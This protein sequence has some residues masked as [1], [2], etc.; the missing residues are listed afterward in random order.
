MRVR[1][2]LPLLLMALAITAGA[3]ASAASAPPPLPEYMYGSISPSLG[4][5]VTVAAYLS[6]QEV[7]TIQSDATGS[8]FGQ[9]GLSGQMLQIQGSNSQ[10][11]NPVSFRVAG[12]PYSAS[13]A[14][15]Y[16]PGDILQ[17]ILSPVPQ[18]TTGGGSTAPTGGGGGGAVTPVPIVPPVPSWSDV[19]GTDWYYHCAVGLFGKGIIQG[20]PDGTFRPNAPVA[21]A[22]FSKMLAL[23]LGYH[24]A[25]DQSLPFADV[26]ATSWYAPYVG[27]AY[28]NG[29][30][31][32]MSPTT[33]DPDGTLTR[34]QA[35]VMVA[36][37]LPA[38]VTPKPLSQFTDSAQIDAWAL[39]QAERGLAKGLVQGYPDGTFRPK[40]EVTRAE[41]VEIICHLLQ[42]THADEAVTSN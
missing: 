29:I 11:G 16:Q 25:I 3:S 12:Q 5:Q 40:G 23:A 39:P 38:S 36:R 7:G 4:Q 42:T 33:F 24:P 22:E 28:R 6:G 37:L 32:G 15:S 2:L 26:P 30:T 17:I 10:V 21:R 1:Y 8:T 27:P 20:Y 18:V 41:A 35:L 9:P 34:E 14:V 19:S 13:P 31:K